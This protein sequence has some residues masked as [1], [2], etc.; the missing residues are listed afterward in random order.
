VRGGKSSK[1][2]YLGDEG[3]FDEG[4]YGLILHLPSERRFGRL[5]RDE[6]AVKLLKCGVAEARA[7]MPD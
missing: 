4:C 2:D 7:D 3:G 6:L 1:S 5:Q